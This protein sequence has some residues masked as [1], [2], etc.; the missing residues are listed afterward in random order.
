M[1]VT[2]A[3]ACFVSKAS[4]RWS[5]AFNNWSPTSWAIRPTCRLLT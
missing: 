4:T 1:T 2:S 3:F 5:R